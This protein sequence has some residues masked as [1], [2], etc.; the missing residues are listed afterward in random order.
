MGGRGSIDGACNVEFQCDH[1]SQGGRKK[2]EWVAF[3]GKSAEEGC[4]KVTITLPTPIRPNEV[5]KTKVTRTL[6]RAQQKIEMKW[7]GV[8]RP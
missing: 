1:S 3:D 4:K 2:Q 6:C 5:G 7:K 8:R